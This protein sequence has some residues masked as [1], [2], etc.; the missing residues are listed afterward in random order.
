MDTALKDNLVAI[1]YD[2]IIHLKKMSMH[3]GTKS[4][5]KRMGLLD[6]YLSCLAETTSLSTQE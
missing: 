1:Q 5:V 2:V 6:L 3:E 4:N